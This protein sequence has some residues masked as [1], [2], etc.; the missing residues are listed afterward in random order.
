MKRHWPACLAALGLIAVV[1]SART[2]SFQ[3]LGDL[4][5]GDFYSEALGISADGSTVV[6]VCRCWEWRGAQRVGRLGGRHP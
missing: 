4:P 6:G 3:G 5:G 1:A 2:P